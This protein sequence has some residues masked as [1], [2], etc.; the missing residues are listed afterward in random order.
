MTQ[1]HESTDFDLNTSL[2]RHWQDHVFLYCTFRN[3]SLEG[4]GFN[5]ALI[6]CVL[7]DMD[8]YWALFN[9]AHFV[10]VEFRHCVFRGA[11][12]AGCTFTECRFINCEFTQDNLGG[13]CRFDDNRWYGCEQSNCVGFV[14]ANLV[15]DR[16]Q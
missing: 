10:N 13:D 8:F 12:I 7:Q 9:T 16:A 2:P 5:G 1:L 14:S 11:G 15:P 6:G 3:M 4:G